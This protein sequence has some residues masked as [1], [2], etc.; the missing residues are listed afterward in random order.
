MKRDLLLGTSVAP[1]PLLM[2]APMPAAAQAPPRA[3]VML[4]TDRSALPIPEPSHPPVTET[5]TVPFE[6][7]GRIG[8][9]KVELVEAKPATAK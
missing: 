1:A 9:V 7:T 5:A 4:P 6:F 2:S 8:S 3:Q